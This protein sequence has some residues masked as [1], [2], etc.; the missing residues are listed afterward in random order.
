MVP[1]G[2]SRLAIALSTAGIAVVNG[3]FERAAFIDLAR[4]QMSIVR[5]RDAGPDGVTVLRPRHGSAIDELGFSRAEL[6]PHTDGAQLNQPPGVLAL[7][8]VKP[9]VSGGETVIVDMAA[10]HDALAIIDPVALRRLYMPD[11]ARFSGRGS[12][13]FA[14]S[15]ERVTVRWRDDSLAEFSPDDAA[16]V[17]RLRQIIDEHRVVFRLKQGQVLF[18]S[19][20][21]FLHGRLRFEGRRLLYRILG[22]PRP[23]IGFQPGFAPPISDSSFRAVPFQAIAPARKLPATAPTGLRPQPSNV[24]RY[25]RDEEKVYECP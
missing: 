9:A 17:S 12:A 14:R 25:P 23:D 6:A 7:A 2:E 22:Y 24:P 3:I 15:G 21:R 5:H 19:N 1:D 8:C 20:S 16:V 18:V 13:V 11:V 4:H 10:V